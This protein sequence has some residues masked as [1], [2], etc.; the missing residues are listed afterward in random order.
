MTSKLDTFVGMGQNLFMSF[1]MILIA[2][3]GVQ[4]A[5]SS[6]EGGAG[7]LDCWRPRR[8]LN[9]CYRRERALSRGITK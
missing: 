8:D 4:S 6:A 5:L 1:A 9:P 2:W 3:F 7:L